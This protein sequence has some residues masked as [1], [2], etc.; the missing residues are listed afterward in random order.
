MQG[1]ATLIITYRFS[2]ICATLF[3][4]QLNIQRQASIDVSSPDAY[5]I[6][7]RSVKIRRNCDLDRKKGRTKISNK[8]LR[9]AL[10]PI[11]KVAM[12]WRGEK[13]GR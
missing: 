13:E 9:G 6:R 2:S 3:L 5:K 4:S 11:E 1:I 8:K 7:L 12:E 10:S